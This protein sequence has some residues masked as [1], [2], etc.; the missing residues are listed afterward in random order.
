MWIYVKINKKKLF[1]DGRSTQ[2]YS[3]EPHKKEECPSVIKTRQT[4]PWKLNFPR[5]QSDPNITNYQ[6]RVIRREI[7]GQALIVLLGLERGHLALHK[8]GAKVRA[9][10]P[11]GEQELARVQPA[12]VAVAEAGQRQV[13]AIQP[14]ELGAERVL[15]QQLHA[16]LLGQLDL[17]VG[18]EEVGVLGGATEQ[19]AV[20]V[21]GHVHFICNRKQ[22]VNISGLHSDL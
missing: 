2:N 15:V 13:L 1:T 3:S 14:P 6:G 8:R 19:V 21:D 17:V 20:V 5:L 4:S 16:G 11:D 12:L 18:V 10:P 7:G 9:L 22:F